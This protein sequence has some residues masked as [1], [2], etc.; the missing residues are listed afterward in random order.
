M[1]FCSG[2]SSRLL[3][4][5]N[6]K[7]KPGSFCQFE[8][9]Y[10]V[11]PVEHFTLGFLLIFSM[12][13]SLKNDKY[14]GLSWSS[15]QGIPSRS[16]FDW[17]TSVFDFLYDFCFVLF[18][19][20]HSQAAALRPIFN[21]IKWCGHRKAARRVF[22]RRKRIRGVYVIRYVRALCFTAVQ[23]PLQ[24]KNPRSSAVSSV[25]GVW[26]GYQSTFVAF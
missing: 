10:R 19:F 24:N 2:S 13:F 21:K 20:W 16:L 14:Q 26:P 18:P 22:Y 7:N 15:L 17:D 6:I 5:I 23:I 12:C 8:A 3:K 25:P 1:Y 11:F 4:T 9:V